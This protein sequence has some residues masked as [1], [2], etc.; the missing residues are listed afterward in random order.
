M[1]QAEQVQASHILVEDEETAKE[2]EQKLKDGEDFA[3][4]AEEYSQDPSNATNGG[5]LG[6]FG[7]VKWFRNLKKLYLQ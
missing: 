1:G 5:E 7:K 2:V 4:L 3:K 6:Y